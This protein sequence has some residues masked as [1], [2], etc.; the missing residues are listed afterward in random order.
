[1]DI[2]EYVFISVCNLQ[3]SYNPTFL[4]HNIVWTSTSC[5]NYVIKVNYFP[6]RQTCM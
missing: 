4:K 6:E 2:L 3:I 1:M 5:A